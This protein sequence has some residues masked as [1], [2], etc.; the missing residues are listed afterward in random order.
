MRQLW[1]LRRELGQR[2]LSCQRLYLDQRYW[3]DLC[4]ATLGTGPAEAI[5]A[6]SQL[7]RLVDQG[8]LIC[9]VEATH[10]SEL[11]EQ[12]VPAKRLATAKVMDALSTRV[13]IAS[14]PDRAFLEILR[15]VQAAPKGPPFPAAPS[16]EVWTRPAFVFGHFDLPDAG[17]HPR[18]E[19]LNWISV[20]TAWQ[21]SYEELIQLHGSSPPS[22][23]AF[24]LRTA[25][26]LNE[27][28][29]ATRALFKSFRKLYMSEVRGAL[30][31]IAL[32]T[33][34]ALAYLGTQAGIDMEEVPKVQ[35][36]EGAKELA[37]LVAADFE[38]HDI[39][40]CLPSVHVHATLV[41]RL[42]WDGPRQYRPNDFPD[43]AHAAAGIPYCNAFATEGPLA[44]LITDAG[45]AREF[46]VS[47]LSTWHQ[48]TTWLETI[49]GAS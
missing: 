9:P 43:F 1:E 12:R 22:P 33:A 23:Y 36:Y 7:Q 13:A 41:A 48:V 20:Q 8:T 45:L 5:G 27:S 3:N 32:D 37:A 49:N 28:K 31:A 46:G 19:E 47:V 26:E 39:G 2:S 11:F 25:V 16:A 18:A 34:G 4:D 21:S 15:F 35:P 10:I 29:K 6:L 17:D 44:A 40:K 38:D 30:D 42:Q 24:K 14:P